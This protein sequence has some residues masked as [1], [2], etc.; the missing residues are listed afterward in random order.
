MRTLPLIVNNLS[1]GINDALQICHVSNS[2]RFNSILFDCS[3]DQWNTLESFCQD[4]IPAF[5]NLH[6]EEFFSYWESLQ[7]LSNWETLKNWAPIYWDFPEARTEH[8][9]QKWPKYSME[10]ISIITL[11]ELWRSSCHHHLRPETRSCDTPH[12]IETFELLP[13][14][15]DS[16]GIAKYTV[17][18]FR[19]YDCLSLACYCCYILYQ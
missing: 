13:G 2:H 4:L 19:I 14:D 16:W 7:E 11:R 8:W 12:E 6:T 3:I 15:L 1:F 9:L 17:N 18:K 5:E 10:S